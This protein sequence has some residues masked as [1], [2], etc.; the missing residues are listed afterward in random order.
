MFTTLLLGIISGI[1]YFYI[2]EK[3]IPRYTNCS[4]VANIWTDILAFIAGFIVIYYGYQYKNRILIFVGVS[5]I[6]EHIM[7]FYGHKYEPF[8]GKKE[9][10]DELNQP[11]NLT[12]ETNKVVDTLVR[13]SSRYALA[14]EQDLSPLVAVL[15][16]NYA[17]GYLWALRDIVSEKDISSVLH[18]NSLQTLES[19]IK[20]VQDSSTKKATKVCPAFIGVSGDHRI[21]SLAGNI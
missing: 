2:M 11:N 10:K 4:Y 7:Q 6:T 16:A 8:S 12:L 17:A 3:D 13:Q 20:K 5:I 1:V 9:E 18:D 14:A 19:Y 21:A 15:H